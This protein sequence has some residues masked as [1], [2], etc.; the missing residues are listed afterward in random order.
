[1]LFKVTMHSISMCGNQ[2]DIDFDN[3]QGFFLQSAVFYGNEKLKH[4]DFDD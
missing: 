1:M 2:N 3:L 4:I